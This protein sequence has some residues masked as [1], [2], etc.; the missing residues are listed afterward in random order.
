V[1]WERVFE[2]L[3]MVDTGFHVPAEKLEAM[4][5]AERGRS[6]L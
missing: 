3:G 5:S 1:L 2:P 6:V 4:A